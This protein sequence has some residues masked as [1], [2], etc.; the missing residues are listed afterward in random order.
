M[1]RLKALQPSDGCRAIAAAFNRN[2]RHRRMTVGK[3]YVAKIFKE[4][5]LEILA[6]RQKIRRRKPGTVDKRLIWAADLTYANN[7]A[8]Q[9]ETIFGL[10]DHGTRLCLRLQ[11]LKTKA[12]VELV[13]QLLDAIELGG[14]PKCLRTDNEPV[15]TSWIFRLSLLLLGIRHQRT[16]VASPWQ[17]GRGMSSAI[18]TT[19]FARTRASTAVRRARSGPVAGAREGSYNS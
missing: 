8:G 1:I 12:S 4:H 9:K 2:Y 7:A 15:F 13:R 14:K 16:Q 6:W 3:S 18:G 10:L 17:N 5:Q 19:I 11:T